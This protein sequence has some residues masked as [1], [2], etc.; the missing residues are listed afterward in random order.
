MRSTHDTMELYS[1]QMVICLLMLTLQSSDSISNI[2]LVPSQIF[3]GFKASGVYKDASSKN[4]LDCYQMC[5]SETSCR[6]F[7][8]RKSDKKC[9]FVNIPYPH[10]MADATFTFTVAMVKCFYKRINYQSIIII[11]VNT[12]FPLGVKSQIL[13]I[14]CKVS[15]AKQTINYDG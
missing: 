15:D 6:S 7:N 4:K 1:L 14:Q 9:Q 3:S 5:L 8:Y 10:L 12:M 13:S 11:T 2:R